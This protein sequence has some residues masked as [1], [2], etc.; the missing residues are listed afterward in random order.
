MNG[1]HDR[2]QPQLHFGEAKGRVLAR[3]PKITREGK[4][5]AFSNAIA[6]YRRNHRLPYFEPTGKVVSEIRRPQIWKWLGLGEDRFE[7]LEILPRAER[8]LAGTRDDRDPCVLVFAK[9]HEAL[10]ELTMHVAIESVERFRPIQSNRDDVVGFLVFA[11]HGQ[12]S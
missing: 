10:I 4:A 6:T 7:L 2:R 9:A 11:S 1:P 3:N 8:T 5:K 12:P